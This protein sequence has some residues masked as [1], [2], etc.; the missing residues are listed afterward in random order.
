M[1]HDRA[2]FKLKDSARSKESRT[3]ALGIALVAVGLAGALAA[4]RRVHLN[5][6]ALFRWR[7]S[8]LSI[9]ERPR[10]LCKF[11]QDQHL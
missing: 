7:L 4:N 10:I 8:A 5:A 6:D 1:P 3:R 2:C 9:L 11:D